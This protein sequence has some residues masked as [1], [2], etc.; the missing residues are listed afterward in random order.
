MLSMLVSSDIN[1][2][3]SKMA[4]MYFSLTTTKIQIILDAADDNFKN[5]F[6]NKNIS[7]L[8]LVR[9]KSILYSFILSYASVII[10]CIYLSYLCTGF[11]CGMVS[12]HSIFAWFG[13]RK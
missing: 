8:R 13:K 4:Q 7:S 6:L 9:L 3:A 5:I 11:G 1:T 10:I 2:S 12:L